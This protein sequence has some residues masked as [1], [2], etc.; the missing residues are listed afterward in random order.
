MSRM[1]S[2]CKGCALS[3]LVEGTCIPSKTVTWDSIASTLMALNPNVLSARH[4]RDIRDGDVH[5]A[6][7]SDS[8]ACYWL[9]TRDESAAHVALWTVGV[10]ACLLCF[11]LSLCPYQR[12]L[13]ESGK[14]T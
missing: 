12:L 2:S 8:F 3:I 1:L 7:S 14:R 10:L 6:R 5:H 4:A 11:L 13:A 9:G